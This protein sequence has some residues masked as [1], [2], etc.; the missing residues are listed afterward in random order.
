MRFVEPT[1]GEILALRPDLTPQVARLV[2]TRMHDEPGP[3]RLAYEGSVVRAQSTGRGELFQVGVELVDAPRPRGDLE[4]IALAEAALGR[5]RVDD[6]T[7]D[8]GHAAVARAAL[9]GLELD[10]DSTAA[11]HAALAKKDAAEVARQVRRAPIPTARRRL[12]AALPSLYGGREVIARARRL[13]DGAAAASLD[14]L[15]RL[16][17][18]LAELGPPARLSVDL[19]EVR[20]FQYYTG[21]RFSIYAAGVGGALSS[22]GRYDGLVARYGRAARATGFAVDVDA[23]AEVQQARG[24]AAP[25]PASGALVSG[26]PVRAARLA[27]RLRASGRRAVLDLDERSA[28]EARLRERAARLGLGR[29]LVIG[30]RGL[31]WL[32]ASDDA[33]GAL[34]AGAFERLLD[35]KDVAALDALVPMK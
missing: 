14:E 17:A 24:V 16:W 25:S 21:T 27:A 3:L 20:G 11:L 13:V 5:A 15:E 12:L 10:E 34:A 28:P 35:G 32:D 18:R 19:G 26:E 9:E 6:V 22:G 30:A 8:L 4:V 1:S 23:V 2:A 31:R 7:L 33:A 29:V